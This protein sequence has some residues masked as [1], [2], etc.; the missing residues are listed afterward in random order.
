MTILPKV[1]KAFCGIFLR[2]NPIKTSL[3]V[4][5]AR[6]LLIYCS[7]FFVSSA[8]NSFLT[9]FAIGCAKAAVNVSKHTFAF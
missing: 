2:K 9:F 6:V 4:A 3:V 8:L 5:M 7:Y 1:F